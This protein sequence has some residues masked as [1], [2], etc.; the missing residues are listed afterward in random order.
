[1]H[2]VFGQVYDGLDVLDAVAAVEV[3]DPD[4]NNYKPVKDV[5]IDKINVKE[6]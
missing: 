1:V 2:T 6:Y 4:N 5:I 3:T